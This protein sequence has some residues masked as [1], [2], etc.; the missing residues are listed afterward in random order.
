MADETSEFLLKVLS[1]NHH[2]AEIIFGYETAV[3]GSENT[4][5]VILSDSLIEPRHVEITFSKEEIRLKPLDGKVFVDGKLVSEESVKVE[6]LQFITIGST[7]MIIGPA[8]ATWPAISAADAPQIGNAGNVE[9]AAEGAVVVD[10]IPAD[11]TKKTKL[12]K[13]K[14]LIYGGIALIVFAFASALLFFVS[15]FQ[16]PKK[17]VE[18]P[19]TFTLLQNVVREMGLGGNITITRTQSGFVASGYT[20]SND[21]LAL[22]RSKLSGVDPSIRRKIYSEEKI[23]T[24][25]S[26]LLL[27]LESHPKVRQTSN[28]VFLITGYAHDKDKW[29]KIRK[30]IIEDVVGIIDLQDEVILPQKAFNMA[31]PILVKYKLTGKIG[32]I[33][34]PDGIA[35]GGLVS[36]DEEENWKL[37]K[38]QLEKTFGSDIVLKNF[39]KVSDPEVI[40]HQ[41]FG[42]EVSSVSISENGMNWIGFK[43]G[44]KYMVGATLSNGYSIKEITPETIVL[45][46]D[47]QTIILK[48]GELK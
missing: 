20:V 42:S 47:N 8:N 29:A 25:I 26:T 27:P 17:I 31:R 28:G 16:E 46:K 23:L 41:Y 38:I 40:K 39:V 24:E 4:S 44:T 43:D 18:K 30:R 6:E 35:I 2:G 33:P 48:I 37:A 32:I 3:I 19:D 14:T 9:A 22:L 5:D 7:H 36:T 34:Q 12:R 1:G 45:V 13:R 21:E 15:M 10:R 11:V